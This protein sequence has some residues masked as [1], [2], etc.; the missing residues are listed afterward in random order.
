MASFSNGSQGLPD[1][2]KR[3]DDFI[4]FVSQKQKFGSNGYDNQVY[5]ISPS[6]TEAWWKKGGENR[7]PNAIDCSIEARPSTIINGYIN[8]FSILV[9]M[10]RTSLITAFISHGTQDR[11][12]PILDPACFGDDPALVDMMQEFCDEQWRFCPVTFSND[13]PM[14]KRII[15]PRQILPIESEKRIEST[16][17]NSKSLIRVVT[18]HPGC[19]DQAWSL[20]G[21]VVFKEYRTQKKENM[22]RSWN[23]EFAAFASIDSC[24]HI[25]QYMGSFEQ[26]NRCFIILEYASGGSLLEL[27][28]QGVPL[29]TPEQRMYFW[30]GLMGLTK[31]INKIQN[32]GGGPHNQRT[33]FAHR[34]INPANILVFPGEHG[35]FSPGFK[36]K[37][38]DFDTATPIRPI[39]ETAA[40]LQDN[41]GNRTYC[42]PEASRVYEE[43]ERDFKQVHVSSDIWSLGCVI[44]ESLVW[45]AG[46]T[47]ALE[48][49][50]NDRRHEIDAYYSN[51]VGSGFETSFH[52]GSILLNCVLQ[53]HKMAVDNLRGTSSLSKVIRNWAEK[54]MLV[55]IEERQEPMFIWQNFDR[56]YN[57]LVTC[58]QKTPIVG[59]LQPGT[60][61]ASEPHSV[62]RRYETPEVP[63]ARSTTHPSLNV[64]GYNTQ[65]PSHHR[66][67]SSPTGSGLHNSP[68]QTSPGFDHWDN[69]QDPFHNM[70]A[71]LAA[72]LSVAGS[73]YKGNLYI[74]HS[75]GA[76][77]NGN[78]RYRNT[79]ITGQNGSHSPVSA[80]GASFGRPSSNHLNP[81]N[82][83]KPSSSTNLYGFTTVESV[84]CHREAKKR[85]EALDGYTSFCRR[86]KPRHFIIVIDDSRSMRIMARGV[87]KVVEVLLWLV[88]DLDS[89]GVDVRFTSDPTKRHSMSSFLRVSTER[90]MMP[91]R[92]WFSKDD[93]EKFCNMKLALNKIFADD[94]IVDPKRPTSILIL[95]DGI[96]EGGDIKESGVE[97]SIS[98]VIKRMG[99]KCVRDTDFT[100][101]FVSFGNDPIGIA[102]L[103]YL[104]DEAT[105]ES[106]G[107]HKVDIVDHKPSTSNVW[108]ILTG[109]M[110]EINDND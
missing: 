20:T 88:K 54:W 43:Q 93:A 64:S 4:G 3:H 26:N 31:A 110:S 85:K 52:N 27:F 82:S 1:R 106:S 86:I 6:E 49:A 69:P 25:V 24:E 30:R 38:A 34:D 37:L 96:W 99:Q 13:I 100:F 45:L 90:L 28:N 40:T 8:I 44:S 47:A 58:T 39:D 77:T 95:T 5:F 55:P 87:L 9:W 50:T 51:M 2:D 32:L 35:L 53:T 61:P 94:K 65:P 36:M 80:Y 21:I 74:Q 42:A 91:L 108:S 41:D 7:I 84:I 103:K 102:R 101:Q 60:R 83:E 72:G 70:Q 104:D 57:E 76:P 92:D 59:Q 46:G 19:F 17:R 18:L 23:R 107:R 89:T 79:A 105:F 29:M 68:T 48:R 33:G 22:R 98:S 16:A 56:M 73:P 71:H 78:G 81:N 63:N 97:E 15:N 62:P 67:I 10:S 109:A 75:P 66:A 12:L 14:D 11:H